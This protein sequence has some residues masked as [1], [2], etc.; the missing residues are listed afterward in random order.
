[1]RPEKEVGDDAAE[2]EFDETEKDGPWGSEEEFE[3]LDGRVGYAVVAEAACSLVEQGPSLW[4][5]A[6]PCEVV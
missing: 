3:F 2:L 1:V 5:S 6:V 4:E